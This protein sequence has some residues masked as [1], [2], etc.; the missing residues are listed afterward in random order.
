MRFDP[1]IGNLLTTRQLLILGLGLFSVATMLLGG[2][3]TGATFAASTTSAGNGA[4]L[5]SL[6]LS[7][8][9]QGSAACFSTAGPGSVDTNV[10]TACPPLFSLSGR[11]PGDTATASVTL[12]NEGSV[13]ATV[14]GLSGSVCRDRDATGESYHGSAS[15][16]ARVQLYVQ[17]TAS[18]FTS[19]LAC[20]YGGTAKPGT[21]DFSNPSRTLADFAGSHG[22]ATSELSLPGGLTPG[23][24][25][26]FVVG[27]RLPW[28]VDDGYQGRGAVVD[29]TWQASR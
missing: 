18:D 26:H 25:R 6:V 4:S 3:R 5:G 21:C 19:P 14:L 12:R 20:H 2:A 29:L 11:R 27:L 23:A 28:D 9:V 8:T 10:N 24:A 17:E 16:C 1:A 15:A 13:P 7:D 22:S